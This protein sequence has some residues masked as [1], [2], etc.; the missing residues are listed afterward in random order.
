M[1]QLQ[2]LSACAGLLSA[3]WWFGKGKYLLNE[4]KQL[5]LVSANFGL[6]SAL[7]GC[8][9]KENLPT[10]FEEGKQKVTATTT[11]ICKFGVAIEFLGAL[12]KAN[13]LSHLQLHA[14]LG[15]YLCS[16]AVWEN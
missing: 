4:Q 7:F 14:H 11:V 16:F 1:G 6:P 10:C 2:L 5:Q 13:A 12:G 9:G 3:S 8:L 15:H